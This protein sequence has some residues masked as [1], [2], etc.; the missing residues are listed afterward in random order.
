MTTGARGAYIIL[1]NQL[2]SKR[3][4][5]EVSDEQQH[6][7]T[8]HEER[9][10][11][12]QMMIA[13]SL[14]KHIHSLLITVLKFKLP[15]DKLLSNFFKEHRR[16]GSNDRHIVAETIYT[17]LRN[18]FKLSRIFGNDYLK[19]IKFTWLNLLTPDNAFQNAMSKVNFDEINK[20]NIDSFN[21]DIP[22]LPDWIYTKLVSQM[23]KDETIRFCHA[24]EQTAP[25]DLRVNLIKV[26][27]KTVLSRLELE[28][29]N[30]VATSFSPFGIRLYNKTFLTKHPLFIEGQIEVQDES[31]QLAGLLLHPKRGEMVVDFCA[32]SGGKTLLL[33]MLMHNTGRVYAFDVHEKR[34]N[35]LGPRLKRS[36]LSNIHPQLIAHEN[37]IKVKRLHNKIDKVFVD[38][39]CLGFGT[40][41]RNPDLKFRQTE[42]SLFEITKK[43]L[44]ILNAASKLVKTGGFL[45]YATCSI[46]KEE[47][48]DI[49]NQFLESNPNFK[50][51]P[52]NTILNN[53]E[54]NRD[55]GYLVLLPHIHH[56]DG[57][58]AAL[59][60][61]QV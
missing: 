20:V 30:P 53:P 50:L 34:L 52:A 58:F 33:G 24:L 22:E 25:L 40:L 2:D 48:Q 14:I 3:S 45:T 16:L 38:A 31:S 12:A 27:R 28:G 35:N 9:N 19:F 43:Q 39:P 56:T 5:F 26:N 11:E 60:Q 41:R 37:D 15:T 8:V 42:A 1:D 46:L 59:L 7:R 21:Q 55:D 4:K 18:Y 44:S 10:Q 57:F 49:V 6:I 17:I 32:G 29:L 36:G 23:G 13:Q 54:L 47:N 61:R 51:I